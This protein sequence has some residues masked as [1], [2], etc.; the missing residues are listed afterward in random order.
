MLE[1][2]WMY[3]GIVAF[4]CHVVLKKML[5]NLSIFFFFRNGSLNKVLQII[6]IQDVSKLQLY[7]V[8]GYW[9]QEGQMRPSNYL[10]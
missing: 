4:L 5:V 10:I 7:R 1:Q 8:K 6:L 3:D 2:A 9:P